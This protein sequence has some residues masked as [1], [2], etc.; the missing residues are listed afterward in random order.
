MSWERAEDES[1]GCASPSRDNTLVKPQRSA[2]VFVEGIPFE[3]P[4]KFIKTFFESE[5]KCGGGPVKRI[6]YISGKNSAVVRFE[7]S[8]GK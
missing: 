4:E 6:Q 1:S 2:A 7:S 5:M 8:S 3:T